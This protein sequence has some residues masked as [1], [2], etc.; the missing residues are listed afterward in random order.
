VVLTA[1]ITATIVALVEQGRSISAKVR[2]QAMNR[3]DA[4]REFR[5]DEIAAIERIAFE[6][7]GDPGGSDRGPPIAAAPR[8]SACPRKLIGRSIIARDEQGH[9]KWSA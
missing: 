5:G 3:L 6:A 7:I 8:N 4:V 9:L 2:Q 1:E